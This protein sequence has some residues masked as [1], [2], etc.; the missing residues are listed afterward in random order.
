MVR[1][2]CGVDE[3]INEIL[4]WFGHIERIENRRIAERL[5]KGKCL[6]NHLGTDC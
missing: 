5:C 3:S 6:E 4:W 1:E 2:F